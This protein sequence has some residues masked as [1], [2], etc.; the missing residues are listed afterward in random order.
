MLPTFT[1]PV[2]GTL[3]DILDNK[4][5]TIDK[6]TLKGLGATKGEYGGVAVMLEKRMKVAQHYTVFKYNPQDHRTT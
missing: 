2:S 1:S 6:K 3:R 4:T 5:T